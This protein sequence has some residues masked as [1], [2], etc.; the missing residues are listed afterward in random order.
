VRKDVRATH[1]QLC[2]QVPKLPESEAQGFRGMGR[3]DPAALQ[4]G[5]H[6]Q[7]MALFRGQPQLSSS[8]LRH[9]IPH[10]R[11]LVRLP[12]DHPGV[13]LA[14]E[15][16]AQEGPADDPQAAAKLSFKQPLPRLQAANDDPRSRTVQTTSPFT[17]TAAPHSDRRH[18]VQ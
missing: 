8:F 5:E 17:G 2:S 18:S 6:I 13:L 1:V 11:A 9:E 4:Q 3:G 16:L 10:D 7:A 12:P 14:A 15:H